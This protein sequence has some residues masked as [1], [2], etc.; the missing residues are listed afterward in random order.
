MDPRMYPY[1]YSMLSLNTHVHVH[2]DTSRCDFATSH[3]P[4][5]SCSNSQKSKRWLHTLQRDS[6][7]SPPKP[8]PAATR[9]LSGGP[10]GIVGPRRAH[11]GAAPSCCG[12]TGGRCLFAGFPTEA[13]LLP[14]SP[15]PQ[16]KPDGWFFGSLSLSVSP[17]VS[18]SVS[19]PTRRHREGR[20]PRTLHFPERAWKDRLASVVYSES[21]GSQSSF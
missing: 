9:P 21:S 12:R 1:E 5:P 17:L 20:C 18:L 2:T 3:S 7:S 8:T 11:P 19:L 13:A 14:P 10:R 4:P 6:H 15:H 16:R